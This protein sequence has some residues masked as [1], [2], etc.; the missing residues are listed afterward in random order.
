MNWLA[1]RLSMVEQLP[2]ALFLFGRGLGLN[3]SERILIGAAPSLPILYGYARRSI[4][5]TPLYLGT[6]LFFVLIGAALL[7]PVA[8]LRDTLLRLGEV[9]MFAVI[10]AC[11][12][13]WHW[14]SPS[15][16]MTGSADRP[17]GG[18]KYSLML[19]MV[20][21][22]CPVLAFRFQGN[23]NLAG[24]LPF[25]LLLISGK[26]LGLL[27]SREPTRNVAHG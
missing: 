19:L 23:E 18:K 4:S 16:L 6:N 2:M 9:N 12:L 17:P 3:I 14:T 24:A 21:A 27:H 8:R 13:V 22:A 20:Y 26:L 5:P 11:G 1:G 15:G 25:I 10:L 7:V